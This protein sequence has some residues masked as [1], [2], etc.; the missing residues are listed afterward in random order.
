MTVESDMLISVVANGVIAID[1]NV[2]KETISDKT[3]NTVESTDRKQST[4]SEGW[5]SGA[6]LGDRTRTDV[7]SSSLPPTA[8]APD[9]ACPHPAP[10]LL[11][12]DAHRSHVNSDSAPP[13][14][15]PTSG[16]ALDAEN[17]DASSC[18]GVLP[19]RTRLTPASSAV[20]MATRC[21]CVCM[22]C[23]CCCC[24]CCYWMICAINLSAGLFRRGD[25]WR[26]E[27]RAR[28]IRQGKSMRRDVPPHI[29]HPSLSHSRVPALPRPNARIQRPR[30]DDMCGCETSPLQHSAPTKAS[31]CTTYHM[32]QTLRAAAPHLPRRVPAHRVAPDDAVLPRVMRLDD[33]GFPTALAFSPLIVTR[34]PRSHRT[35][36]EIEGNCELEASPVFPFPSSSPFPEATIESEITVISPFLPSKS[37]SLSPRA[38][39][40]STQTSTQYPRIRPTS[41]PRSALHPATQRNR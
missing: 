36:I 26:S 19:L 34:S 39:V 35:P 6:G 29:I 2:K 20:A 5:G 33:A 11:H 37:L 4:E 41:R 1:E 10:Q 25:A 17:G 30:V 8:P 13:S 27:R 22:P 21:C 23:H 15:V 3:T 16:P 31:E 12:C 28:T 7:A 38:R 9:S 24:C 14:I 18:L 32:P 40:S